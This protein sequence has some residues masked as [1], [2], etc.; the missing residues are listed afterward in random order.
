MELSNTITVTESQRWRKLKA[1]RVYSRS[2]SKEPS[3]STSCSS[4]QRMISL[5]N[6]S[7]SELHIQIL[8][9]FMPI[10]SWWG[11]NSTS[12]QTT[13]SLSWINSFYAWQM[14]MKIV[15]AHSKSTLTWSSH[16]LLWSPRSAT[17]A[18]IAWHSTLRRLQCKIIE[19]PAKRDVMDKHLSLKVSLIGRRKARSSAASASCMLRKPRPPCRPLKQHMF[20]NTLSIRCLLVDVLDTTIQT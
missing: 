12:R 1:T 6:L 19:L 5:Q 9:A 8:I 18:T 16:W 15:W 3:S 11:R 17:T 4:R 14:K 20:Q 7:W 2:R 10:S 13:S